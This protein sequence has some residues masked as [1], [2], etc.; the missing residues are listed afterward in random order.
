MPEITTLTLLLGL[1]LGALLYHLLRAAFH[2]GAADEQDE[3]IKEAYDEGKKAGRENRDAFRDGMDYCSRLHNSLKSGEQLPILRK[4][5]NNR[6]TPL[7]ALIAS[8]ESREVKTR[9][10]S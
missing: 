5:D 3:K 8:S 9:E 2:S 1:A 10:T 7:N 4:S 6:P